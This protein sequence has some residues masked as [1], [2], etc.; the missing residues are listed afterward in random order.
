VARHLVGANLAGHDSHGVQRLPQY[1]AQVDAGTLVPSARA[2]IVRESAVLALFDGRRG[3][4]HPAVWE[5]CGWAMA[6]AARSGIAAAGVR[7]ATHVGRLGDYT[8]RVARAGMVG[9]LTLGIAGQGAGLAAPFGGTTRFLGTNPWSIGLPI[10]E[11]QPFVMDFASTTVAEGKVRVARAAGRQVPEGALL[12]SAGSPTRDPDRLYDGGSLTLLGGAVAGHKGY[13]LSLA[14]A[15]LGALAMVDDPDPSPAG[16]MAGTPPNPDYAAGVFLAV[17]DP[18]WFGG[19]ERYARLAAGIAAQARGNPPAPGV[20]AVMIP[21]EPEYIN[22]LDRELA[23]ISLPEPT[24]R[25][26]AALGE[27]FGVPLPPP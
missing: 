7:H 25:E 27:R 14:A 24:W 3:F 4:S 15:M 26:L 16:T 13:G 9:I 5:A 17:L 23:G 2:K 6:H 11:G 8:D 22:R 19:R 21:G 10:A 12:D 1:L 18:E 20:A